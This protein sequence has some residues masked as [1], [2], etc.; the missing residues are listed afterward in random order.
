[1]DWAFLFSAVNFIALIAWV[2]LI[3]LPRAPAILSAV[4]YAGVGLLCLVY[5]VSFFAFY[6]RV[7][8]NDDESMYRRQTALMVEGTATVVNLNIGISDALGSA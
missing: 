7:I 2:V 5:A 4:M 8:T 6:P 1:M 3:F